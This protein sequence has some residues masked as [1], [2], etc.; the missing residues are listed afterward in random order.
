MIYGGAVLF[1]SLVLILHFPTQ[2]E[3]CVKID[4]MQD[5]FGKLKQEV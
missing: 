5:V 4:S 3:G 2:A 1:L